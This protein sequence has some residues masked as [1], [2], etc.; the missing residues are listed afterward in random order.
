MQV[1]IHWGETCEQAGMAATQDVIPAV[2]GPIVEMSPADATVELGQTNTVDVKI[3]DADNLGGFEF[4]L[5]FDS[6]KVQVTD[7][8]LGDFLGNTGRNTGSLGPEIDN[9]NGTVFFGGFSYGT[10]D[11]PSGEGVLATITFSG[12]EM[13]TSALDLS[14]VQVTDKNATVQPTSAVNDGEVTVR[15]ESEVT[16]EQNYT[17]TYTDT[18][19]ISTTVQVPSGAVTETVTLAYTAVESTTTSPADFSFAGRAFNLDVYRNGELQ[20]GFPF[21]ET[22]T[23]ELH[24]TNDDLGDL[25]EGSLLLYYWDENQNPAQWV[26]AGTTCYPDNPDLAYDRHLGDNWLGVSVCH[27]TEFALFGQEGSVEKVYL[28]IVV[29]NHH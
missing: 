11:G 19:G 13:G 21:E 24:Y 18:Q 12:V 14:D 8:T 3:Q 29:R 20:E 22:V 2:D 10:P 26:D 7:I 1:A 4:Q 17:I 9:D 6:D 15:L 28:P 16:P 27:L 25:N 23:I 5:A